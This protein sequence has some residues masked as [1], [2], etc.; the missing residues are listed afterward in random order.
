MMKAHSVTISDDLNYFLKS[1]QGSNEVIRQLHMVAVSR[2]LGISWHHGAEGKG[3]MWPESQW[4][5]RRGEGTAASAVFR[6]VEAPSGQSSGAGQG[7]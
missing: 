6:Q 7:K 5:T 2:A 4:G 1:S 3:H